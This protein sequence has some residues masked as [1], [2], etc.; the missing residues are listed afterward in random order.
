MFK[1]SFNAPIVQTGNTPSY[2]GLAEYLDEVHEW[3][4]I[5]YPSQDPDTP[6]RRYSR[7]MRISDT[8]DAIIA[9]VNEQ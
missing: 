1:I 7:V 3:H 6:G 5:R 8:V 9:K 2:D 4:D